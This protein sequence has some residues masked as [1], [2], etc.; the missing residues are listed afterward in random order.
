[1]PQQGIL[2]VELF[3]LWEIDLMGPFPPSYNK[4]YILMAV[5]CICLLYTSD[6]ADE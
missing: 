5:D 1:M 2:K 6:A 3:G 4:L